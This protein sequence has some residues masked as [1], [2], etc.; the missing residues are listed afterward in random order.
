MNPHVSTRP[1]VSQLRYLDFVPGRRGQADRIRSVHPRVQMS[2]DHMRSDDLRPD[3]M[4]GDQ[5]M[6]WGLGP[7]SRSALGQPDGP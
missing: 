3:H 6:A 2:A 1:K 7:T 5:V 4:R